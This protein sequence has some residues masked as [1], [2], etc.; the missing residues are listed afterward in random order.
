[1]AQNGISSV[2]AL[3]PVVFYPFVYELNLLIPWSAA[4][5]YWQEELRLLHLCL[6]D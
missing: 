3:I 2:Y 6:E 1:M 4:S 5:R